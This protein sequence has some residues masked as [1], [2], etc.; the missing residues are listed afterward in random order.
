VSEQGRQNVSEF[1]VPRPAGRQQRVGR[2]VQSFLLMAVHRG[3]VPSWNCRPFCSNSSEKTWIDRS[4]Y[5]KVGGYLKNA[6]VGT[7]EDPLRRTTTQWRAIAREYLDLSIQ[8]W[9][10]PVSSQAIAEGRRFEIV[11]RSAP[12]S[13]CS[14]PACRWRSKTRM[15]G[16]VLCLLAYRNC[17]KRRF[18][19]NES[20]GPA[21]RFLSGRLASF[22]DVRNGLNETAHT[23]LDFSR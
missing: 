11:D 14:L 6:P 3:S 10:V 4:K 17:G 22:V 2:L 13:L 12:V 8:Q 16:G 18:P 21:Y 5:G 20:E 9:I 19:A 15:Q 1:D 23:F 7:G